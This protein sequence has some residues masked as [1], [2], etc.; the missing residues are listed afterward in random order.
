MPKKIDDLWA[1]LDK[2]IDRIEAAAIDDKLASAVGFTVRQR[3]LQFISRGISPILGAARFP[4]YK[5]VTRARKAKAT[6]RE[7][8]KQARIQRNMLR[9]LQRNGTRGQI[10]KDLR[11]TSRALSKAAK[12]N[13]VPPGYPY[14]TKEYRQGKKRPRPVN[15]W[16]T[17]DFLTALTFLI[18]PAGKRKKIQ[19]GWEDPKE[20]IKEKGHREGAGGQPKRPAL[21]KGTQKFNQTIQLD[22]M[23]L[24][25]DAVTKAAKSAKRN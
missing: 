1:E 22:I 3:M 18:L 21:P 25:R 10:I 17:G 16:L 19:M 23:K 13:K 12:A 7:L 8:R 24:L 11:R 4:E 20:A 2:Y 15:L 6:N 14:N 9:N 5:N